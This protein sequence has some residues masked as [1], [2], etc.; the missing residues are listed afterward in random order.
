MHVC[1]CVTRFLCRIFNTN[2]LWINLNAVDRLM[3]A[4]EGMHME[5]IVNN[6]VGIHTVTVVDSDSH[7]HCS[8]RCWAMDSKSSNL[9]QLL[10]LP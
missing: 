4:P 1:H 9:R 2:N 5:V 7:V 6:K 3:K 10:V 8:F